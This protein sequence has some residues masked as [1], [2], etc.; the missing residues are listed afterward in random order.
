MKAENMSE[1][2]FIRIWKTAPARSSGN[3]RCQRWLSESCGPQT[4]HYCVSAERRISRSSGD[5]GMTKEMKSQPPACCERGV[6]ICT[7]KR[8]RADVVWQRAKQITSEVDFH[9]LSLAKLPAPAVHARNNTQIL[10]FWG[11]QLMRYSAFIRESRLL[12][13][14]VEKL[15]RAVAK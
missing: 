7:R 6:L 5:C 2:A 8:E 1:L 4:A 3:G 10:Q 15:P 11:A 9:F 14:A 12:L 13:D